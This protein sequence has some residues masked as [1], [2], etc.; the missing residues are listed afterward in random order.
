MLIVPAVWALFV[1]GFYGASDDLHIS[2]LYEMYKTLSL[3]QI[4][5][6]FVPD[7]SYGFGYP[8]FNFVFPLPFYLGAVFHFFGLSLVDSVKGVFLVSLVGSAFAMYWLLRQFTGTWLALAGAVVYTYTPYRSTDVYVRGAIG[9]ALAFV[10]FPL[11]ILSIYKLTEGVRISWR[12]IGLGS[13][14]VAGLV[15][16]HNI[17]AYMFAPFAV[18]FWIALVF[19]KKSRVAFLGSILAGLLGLIISSYF[20]I[21][22]ILESGL[23][24]YDTV[25][26]FIDHFPTIK[27]LLTPYW[28]YGASVP[29][30]YDGMSFFIGSINL[31]IVAVSLVFV[32]SR[33]ININGKHKI[34]FWWA[35]A[36]FIIAFLMM[37]YRSTIL[38]QNIPLLTFFQFPWRF[39]TMTTFSTALLVI[40]FNSFKYKTWLALLIIVGCLLTAGLDFKPHDFLGRTDSYYLNRYIPVPSASEAYRQTEEEVRLPKDVAVPPDKNYP[41][42]EP[43][44][45]VKSEET[46]NALKSIF[47]V[48][49][50]EQTVIN[51]NKFNFPGWQVSVDGETV[52]IRSGKPFGQVS[53]I[54]PAG[55]HQIVVDFKETKFRLFWDILSLVGLIAALGL[56]LTKSKNLGIGE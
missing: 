50:N 40:I 15:L 20:W 32:L 29:G 46:I 21:P 56:I 52:P 30:P 43:P 31:L 48:S 8:L 38:W 55:E 14:A 45:A 53:F 3:G 17:S 24:K 49:I 41:L 36:S 39:L 2:R 23:M 47:T 16:S 10:F 7:L 28:G 18:I 33:R 27:Q 51:F 6:R 25:F 13:L 35:A 9:E 12:W 34:L 1:P 4:P 44:V 26:N 19:V 54:V 11:I 22:A 42:I 37:N 5:P